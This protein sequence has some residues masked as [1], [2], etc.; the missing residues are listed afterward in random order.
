MAKAKLLICGGAGYI[1]S[2]TAHL[3]AEEG[4]EVHVLDNLSTGYRRAVGDLPFFRMDVLDTEA[5]A[6]HMQARHYE[7]VLHFAA[8]I[9]V[10]ESVSD[11]LKYYKNNVSGTLSLLEAMR[12]SETRRLV[13]SSTAAVYG[14]PRE[15]PVTEEHPLSPINPY[16][17][18]KRMMEQSMADCDRA[19]GLRTVALRYFN[20]AGALPESSG[21]WHR[22]ETHLIPLALRATLPDARPLFVFGEDY[23]TPDGTCVRDYI[24]VTD[25]A[26]AHACSLN[27]LLNGGESR[28]FNLGAERGYS[29]REVIETAGRVT[30]RSVNWKSAPRREGDPAVLVAASGRIRQAFGWK[31]VRSDLESI[32]RDAWEWHRENGFEGPAG[33]GGDCAEA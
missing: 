19:W 3:L 20:A 7:A 18:S 26:R 24:H 29:V 25:L 27:H 33:S 17:W 9:A 10:G 22:P 30:G 2:I 8:F 15:T 31:P 21:E 14:E 32:V 12:R 5:L 16:G 11:P 28:T 23:D 4:F 13:F 6:R 1:G